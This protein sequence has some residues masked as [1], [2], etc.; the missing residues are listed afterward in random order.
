[1]CKK[2]YIYIYIYVCEFVFVLYV[3]RDT[4]GDICL[5]VCG[6]QPENSIVCFA[7]KPTQ[8]GWVR[9]RKWTREER[10]QR[11]Q[12]ESVDKGGWR[13]L[14]A[15]GSRRDQSAERDSAKM[16]VGHRGDQST[17]VRKTTAKTCWPTEAGLTNTRCQHCKGFV[18]V[19]VSS[20]DAQIC[21]FSLRVLGANPSQC[22]FFCSF[23]PPSR[24]CFVC[25]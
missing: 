8:G 23:L 4:M 1:M 25:P 6:C 12:R 11:K 3:F 16:R 10:S 7:A 2:I 21:H 18:R 9:D 5:S 22:L 24:L 15:E 13:E 17:E 14:S 19:F 20:Q